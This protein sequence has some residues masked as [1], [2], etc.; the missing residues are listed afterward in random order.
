MSMVFFHVVMSLDGYVAPEGMELEHAHDP[1]YKD[2]SRQWERLQGWV[3]PQKFFRETLKL[4]PGGEIGEDNRLL[5]QTYHR[6]GVTILGKRI[7][8]GGE[9]FWPEEA[10]FHTPVFVLTHQVRAPWERPGGTT[11]YFVNDGVESASG[12]RAR[13]PVDATS[14]SEAAP[15]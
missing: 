14:A 12:G 9:L 8:D 2:W 6:T 10:P 1:A 11:F 7:F 15:T 5:E 4:G 13:W 3:F